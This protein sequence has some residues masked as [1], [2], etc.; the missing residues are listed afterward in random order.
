M[1]SYRWK[2]KYINVED[3]FNGVSVYAI[4]LHGTDCKY[5]IC[6]VCVGGYLW[7]EMV[8]EASSKKMD[9]T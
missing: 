7:A 5:I 9:L 8:G 6:F 2:I 4:M 1:G 3:L